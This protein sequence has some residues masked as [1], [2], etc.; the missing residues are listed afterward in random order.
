M[1]EKTES[2]DKERIKELKERIKSMEKIYAE[3]LNRR[4]KEVEELKERNRILFQ[5]SVK[6]HDK[7]EELLLKLK[8]ALEKPEKQDKNR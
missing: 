6:N 3:E 4:D 7:V 8:K 1:K 5:A 2:K